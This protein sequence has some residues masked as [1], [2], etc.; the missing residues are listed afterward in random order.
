MTSLA[1]YGPSL[2]WLPSAA[3]SAAVLMPLAWLDFTSGPVTARRLADGAVLFGLLWV[4]GLVA[5][6]MAVALVRGA[7]RDSA[8]PMGWVRLW[9]LLVCAT[10][11]ALI[12]R[13]QLP[14]FLGVP[15]C[16]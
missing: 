1:P 5:V 11:W 4:L 6:L 9:V 7:A 2:R 3:I 16:D 14:C 12:V 13:D 8:T 10:G 15:N